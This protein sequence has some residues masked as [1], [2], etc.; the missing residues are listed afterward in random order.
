MSALT[1]RNNLPSF[2]QAQVSV[3]RL[4][5][6]HLDR[7]S[8][9]KSLAAVV[10]DIC[11]IQAQVMS[12]AQLALWARVKNLTLEDVER[13]LWQDH[14]LVKTWCMRG[15]VHLLPA[16][17]L[18]VY[19][20][21]YRLR[22]T[23]SVERWLT[24]SGIKPV[25]IKAMTETIVEA[26][27]SGPLTRRELTE[28]VVSILGPRTKRWVG[29]SWGGVVKQPCY[30]GRVCFGPNQGQEISFVRTDQWLPEP[31][32]LPVKEAETALFRRYLKSY[33]PV[34]LGDFNYWAGIRAKEAGVILKRMGAE[35][36][37]VNVEGRP[38]LILRQDLVTL[39]KP[40]PAD[41][42]RLLPS[43]DSYLLGHRNKDHLVDAAHY[44]LVFRKAGWL[45][46]VVLVNGKVTGVWNYKRNGKRL[47]VTIH[48]FSRLSRRIR[49][50]IEDEAIDLGRFWS[51]RCE[52]SFK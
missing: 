40:E 9:L 35:V 49:D 12:A 5:R 11:G 47:S 1:N 45:S 37:E 29:H 48:P 26:L 43:F 19:T 20:G 39:R 10:G 24:E 16:A 23:R 18:P 17:E 33:G 14:T 7:R 4:R 46:P 50:R 31:S 25:E 42:V 38:A 2:S 36:K 28:K 32:V 34:T 8:P 13:A 21:A 22:G 52:I 51:V 44:K 30:Q 41:S 6:H 3:F 27:A 15:T